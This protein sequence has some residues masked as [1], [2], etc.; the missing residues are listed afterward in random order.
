MITEKTEE[1]ELVEE[2]ID[3]WCYMD[4]LST[5]DTVNVAEI[6]RMQGVMMLKAER[7]DVK[8]RWIKSLIFVLY[9]EPNQNTSKN[10]KSCLDDIKENINFITFQNEK[11]TYMPIKQVSMTLEEKYLHAIRQVSCLDISDKERYYWSGFIAAYLACLEDKDNDK[12]APQRVVDEII[13]EM[14]PF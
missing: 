13:D 1:K 9:S 7:F 2:L 6:K 14:P 3:D 5:S 11:A 10:V 8:I 4:S 12:P